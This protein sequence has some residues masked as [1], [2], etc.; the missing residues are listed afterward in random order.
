[1]P[2]AYK[3]AAGKLLSNGGLPSGESTLRAGAEPVAS[4]SDERPVCH[5][6][7]KFDFFER[8]VH[9]LKVPL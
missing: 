4:A 7:A 2:V 1:M 6:G 5:F 3:E 8:W 9:A